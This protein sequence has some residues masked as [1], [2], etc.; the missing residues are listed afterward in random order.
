VIADDIRDWS[1]NVLEVPNDQLNGLPACPYAKRAWLDNKVKVIETDDVFFE[2]LQNTHYILEKDYQLVIVASYTLPDATTMES[3]IVAWNE[4][5][6]KKDLYFMCFHPDYGAEDAELDF[7]YEHDWE[8]DVDDPYCMIFIQ[9][10][11]EVDDKSRQLD[12]L[13]Y[14]KAFPEDEYELLVL[15][16]RKLREQYQ[17][18]NETSCND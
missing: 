15:N 2:A 17:N 11:T 4:L 3:T 6:A 18:G 9:R 7:L 8:S 13:G 14:Y 12:K 10:L 1:K 16:R 5:A